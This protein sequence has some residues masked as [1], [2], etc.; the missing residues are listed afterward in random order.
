MFELFSNQSP[1]IE[2]VYSMK[3]LCA[4]SFA[5]LDVCKDKTLVLCYPDTETSR[6]LT[7]RAYNKY[8]LISALEGGYP[9]ELGESHDTFIGACRS[10]K[11]PS[12]HPAA[13]KREK[14]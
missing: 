14:V 5:T 2:G 11:K 1:R 9:I 7:F 4:C 10:A 13:L 8:V 3:R 6:V 12:V